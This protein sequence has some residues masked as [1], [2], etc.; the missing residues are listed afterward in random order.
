MDDKFP[1]LFAT[2][3]IP[4][5]SRYVGA[6]L[7]VTIGMRVIMSVLGAV[8]FPTEEQL[9]RAAVRRFLGHT[10]DTKDRRQVLPL[11]LGSLELLIFPVLM[12]AG[13]WLAVGAW[14]TFKTLGQW[15]EWETNRPL[16][17]R[18]LIGNALQLMA[19]YWIA[20]NF[21]V[22]PKNG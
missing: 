7:C 6:V 9:W 22:L 13:A 20:L 14:I 1:D 8:V 12:R 15:R 16:F 2:W 10:N 17:N 21:V 5:V 18:F 11:V 3:T 4:S 19:S